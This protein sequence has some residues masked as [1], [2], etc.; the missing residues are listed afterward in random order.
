M[1]MDQCTNRSYYKETASAAAEDDSR[2]PPSR[3]AEISELSTIPIK[4]LTPNQHF[5]DT[6]PGAN[7][8]DLIDVVGSREALVREAPPLERVDASRVGEFTPLRWHSHHDEISSKCQDLLQESNRLRQESMDKAHLLRTTTEKMQK[9]ST[10]GL[11][12]RVSRT[13]EAKEVLLRQINKATDELYSLRDMKNRLRIALHSMELPEN[14]NL[15][16]IGIRDYRIG[17][18]NTRDGVK[19]SLMKETE[20]LRTGR[21]LLTKALNEIEEGI[22]RLSEIK[23]MLENDWSDKVEAMQLDHSAAKLQIR[24]FLAQFKPVSEILNEGVSTPVSWQNE[25]E[26]HV[27]A[28][29]R[30]I[31]V[32]T[33]L[34]G[35]AE[36]ALIEVCNDII[37]IYNSVDSELNTSMEKLE[38]ALSTLREEDAQTRREIADQEIIICNLRQELEDKEQPY[39]VAQ[40]RHYSRSFR[41]GI[42]RCLDEP[43][44]RLKSEL[45][46]FPKTISTLREQICQSEKI[47]ENLHRLHEE[48]VKN[49]VGREH[50]LSLETRCCN[51]RSERPVSSHLQGF[52]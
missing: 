48:L 33:Q 4:G 52:R 19:Y 16:C 13:L 10:S 39:Q 11:D 15:E 44:F 40:T 3:V 24:P 17:I 51:V 12:N 35:A 29:E 6:V 41:P 2:R 50:T 18:D 23:R 49:I 42:D 30:E 32:T 43:H 9:E 1:D 7:A 28:N 8:Y 34:R 36:H 20:I 46:E 22:Y 26:K 37:N 38:S 45:E 5:Y 47:L 21:S 27:S 25:I 14:N 31:A